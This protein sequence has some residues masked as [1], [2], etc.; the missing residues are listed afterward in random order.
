VGGVGERKGWR[1]FGKRG[2]NKR[3]ERVRCRKRVERKKSWRFFWRLYW[4]GETGKISTGEGEREKKGIL[5]PLWKS[6]RKIN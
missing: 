6:E 4:K 3:R 5:N 1:R 2:E